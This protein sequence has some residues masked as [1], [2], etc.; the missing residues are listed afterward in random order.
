[1]FLLKLMRPNREERWVPSKSSELGEPATS[2]HGDLVMQL[3]LTLSSTSTLQQHQS[4]D[5]ILSPQRCRE[6]KHVGMQNTRT[7]LVSQP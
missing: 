7:E 2:L 5:L 1:M 4:R 3:P 6:P